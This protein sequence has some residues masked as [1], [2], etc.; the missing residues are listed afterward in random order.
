MRY[1]LAAIFLA[2]PAAADYSDHP[3]VKLFTEK[4]CRAAMAA[5]DYDGQAIMAVAEQGMAWGFLLGF[6]TASAGLAGDHETTLQRL[7]IACAA[8]PETPA[9][10]LLRGFK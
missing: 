6:D 3:G 10:D 2:T 9:A 8:S 4:P 1:L 5:M 7:R